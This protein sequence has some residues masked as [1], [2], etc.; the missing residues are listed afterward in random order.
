MADRPYKRLPG[1]SRQF[2]N[3]VTLWEGADHLLLVHSHGVTESYR[4]FFHRDI[5][6]IV[7]CQTRNGL[8]QTVV[9]GLLGLALAAP[10]PFVGFEAAVAF[11]IFAGLFFLLAL[12]NF[13]RGAT[14]RCT[15]RTAVQTQELPSLNRVRTARKVLTRIQPAIAAAQREVAVQ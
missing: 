9:L 14:C 1:R 8:V 3:A 10:A 13:L 11:G 5:Q 4:R 12:I 6:A 7:V 2:F 15:L